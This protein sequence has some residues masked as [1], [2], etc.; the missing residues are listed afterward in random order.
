MGANTTREGLLNSRSESL[1]RKLKSILH[2]ISV[3]RVPLPSADGTRL[4]TRLRRESRLKRLHFENNNSSEMDPS[5]PA[6]LALREVPAPNNGVDIV[7][8]KS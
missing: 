4:A 7:I 3:E 8:T 6:V 1:R 2:K 5:F